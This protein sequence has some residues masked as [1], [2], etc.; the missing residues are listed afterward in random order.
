MAAQ[1]APGLLLVMV[2][3]PAAIEADFNRLY[4]TLHLP[5]V[6]AVPGVL[7][8]RRYQ[9]VEAG[10]PKYQ[11]LY[12]LERAD[13]VES[14]AFQEMT[15]HQNEWSQRIRPQFQNLQRGVFTQIHPAAQDTPP[16]PTE[17][18]GVL[19]VG[20]RV[21]L[22]RDEEFNVW[23]N[24]E[25]LPFLAAVPGVLRARRFAAVDDPKK[26]LAVYEL[27]DPD[28]TQSEAFQKAANTPWTARQRPVFQS[29]VRLR[30]R[31]LA[32]VTA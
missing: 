6:V 29:W 22:E 25:H 20:L 15:Q 4:D 28:V 21:P 12:D 17:V 9:A 5:E 10:A 31:A 27:S 16:A 30:S 14:A 11:A 13:V 18:G 1:S 19:L 2:D 32:A 3:I 23:Y 8:G 26:Y 24:T 7:G